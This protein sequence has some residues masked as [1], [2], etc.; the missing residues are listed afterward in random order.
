MTTITR[1]RTRSGP[2]SGLTED[3]T[4]RE[5]ARFES[6]LGFTWHGTGAITS[7]MWLRRHWGEKILRTPL[8]D[9]VPPRV[10]NNLQ[11]VYFDRDTSGRYLHGFDMN[12]MYLGASSSLALP[13]GSLRSWDV[14]SDMPLFDTPGYWR[15]QIVDGDS[16]SYRWMTTPTLLHLIEIGQ[17]VEPDRGYYWAASGRFLAPWYQALRN[18]RTK[19]ITE[20]GPALAAVKATYAEGIGRLGSTNRAHPETDPLY[21]PYWRH[22]V[23]AQARTNLLRRIAKLSEA[24]VVID[25]DAI[26][27]STN[28]RD[29]AAFAKRIGLPIGYGVGHFKHKGTMTGSEARALFAEETPGIVLRGLR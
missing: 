4:I 28:G 10:E 16:W 22:A 12:A 6:A 27:F 23:I 24:P 8:P 17:I 9:E 2:F 3:E 14:W 19:L 1:Q 25:I 29:P 15:T 5:L 26:W 20:G 7:E 13:N 18:A 11:M 21:Q